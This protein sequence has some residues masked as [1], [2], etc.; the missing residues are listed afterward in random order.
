MDIRQCRADLYSEDMD[1]RVMAVGWLM[2][3]SEAGDRE[4]LYEHAVCLYE[5]IAIPKNVNEAFLLFLRSAVKGYQ[6]AIDRVFGNAEVY[7]MMADLV[8]KI[9]GSG[10]LMVDLRAGKAEAQNFIGTELLALDDAAFSSKGISVKELG[11]YW[12]RVAAEQGNSAA[13]YGLGLMY[14]RGLVVE[15]N[16]ELAFKYFALA[17]EGGHAQSQYFTGLGRLVAG[18]IDKAREWFGKA[19]AQGLT[20]AKEE[21]EKLDAAKDYWVFLDVKFS[22]EVLFAGHTMEKRKSVLMLKALMMKGTVVVR[23]PITDHEIEVMN[24][25]IGDGELNDIMNSLNEHGRYVREKAAYNGVIATKVKYKVVLTDKTTNKSELI[26]TCDGLEDA[27]CMQYAA[28][29]GVDQSMRSMF[30]HKYTENM[31][32]AANCIC[33]FGRYIIGNSE[34]MAQLI[35]VPD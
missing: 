31:N 22:D 9:G 15:V 4:A 29:I 11:Y 13:R 23:D 35:V 3:M 8:E 21:L 28:L 17:A 32:E 5:G 2:A 33:S 10:N 16:K 19:A 20:A 7:D 27:V 18:D 14:Y 12:L 26:G 1:K 25:I 34:E 24:K 6:P 30:K